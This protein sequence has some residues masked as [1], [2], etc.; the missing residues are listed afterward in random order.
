MN[1]ISK[2]EL[3]AIV[4]RRYVHVIADSWVRDPQ[5]TLLMATHEYLVPQQQQ[6]IYLQ[7]E[8]ALEQY[9]SLP[10]FVEGFAG[11]RRVSWLGFFRSSISNRERREAEALTRLATEGELASDVLVELYPPNIAV[12]GLDV[13]DV[14][15]EQREKL[16][17]IDSRI[18]SSLP[19]NASDQMTTNAFLFGA[20]DGLF[21]AIVD[22]LEDRAPNPSLKELVEAR[23]QF[24]RDVQV[25]RYVVT[26][27]R[28]A[29]P[30]EVDLEAYP[31]ICALVSGIDMERSLDFQVVEQERQALIQELVEYATRRFTGERANAIE[32][33]LEASRLPESAIEEAPHENLAGDCGWMDRLIQLSW[34]YTNRRMGITLYYARLQGLIHALGINLDESTPL[35]RYIRYVMTVEELDTNELMTVELP[36]LYAELADLLTTSA[37]ERGIIEL[38]QRLD[39]LRRFCTLA[40]PARKVRTFLG[41][42]PSLVGWV[43]D[44]LRLGDSALGSSWLERRTQLTARNVGALLE[45]AVPLYKEYYTIACRRSEQMAERAL[46]AENV[47][48]GIAL[49]V[50]GRFHLHE[51]RQALRHAGNVSWA[52][53]APLASRKEPQGQMHAWNWV[54]PDSEWSMAETLTS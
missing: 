5:L 44:T 51:A 24:R 26:L 13:P 37:R 45:K 39:D 12:I 22:D 32:D 8:R 11:P 6:N 38:R 36:G 47:R 33:W 28:I 41:E 4:D 7:L 43:E 29:R 34:A 20:F 52:I 18:Q 30:Q 16:K 35:G 46:R 53:L 3:D 23:R 9:P 1:R 10:V 17:S 2:A 50:C 40:L 48:D 19:K 31:S 27:T 49:W 54:Y 21:G 15:S 25:T 42:N 14:L